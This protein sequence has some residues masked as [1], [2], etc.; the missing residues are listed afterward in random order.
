MNNILYNDI[1]NCGE[2]SRQKNLNDYYIKR[3][4]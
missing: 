3:N 4:T 1:V 2:G